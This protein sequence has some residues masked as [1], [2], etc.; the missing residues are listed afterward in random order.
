[1]I[2]QV[3]NFCGKDF[4]MWDKQEAFGLHHHVGYGSE[5]DGSYIDVDMCCSCFDKLMNTY[6]IPNCKISPVGEVGET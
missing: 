4:D 6:V 3:C 2:K 1:V 5:F